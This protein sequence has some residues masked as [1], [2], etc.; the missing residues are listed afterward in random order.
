MLFNGKRA[1][2][3][4]IF[5]PVHHFFSTKFNRAFLRPKLAVLITIVLT[6]AKLNHSTL[7]KLP[8]RLAKGKVVLQGLQSC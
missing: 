3:R 6:E 1:S 5:Q 2:E 7:R 8:F 4:E